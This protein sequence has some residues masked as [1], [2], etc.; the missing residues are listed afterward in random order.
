MTKIC[1]R[2]GASKPLAE[3]HAAPACRDGHR[4]ECRACTNEKQ[5]IRM[6]RPEAKARVK[7][8][9]SRPEIRAR[10]NAARNS[11][12]G[13]ESYWRRARISPSFSLSFALHRALKRRP[14]K[15]PITHA[16]LMAMFASQDGCC[17]ITGIKMVWQRGSLQPN[18]MTLDRIDSRSDYSS[19]NI[20]LICH[21]V[22]M[23]RGQMHDDEMLAM[24]RAVVAQSG[25]KSTE[26]TWQNFHHF[27]ENAL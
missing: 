17:A 2:C 7:E 26:P 1:K 4:G 25:A 14:S 3:F 19:G 12:K 24:A 16:E 11:P 27:T 22:N 6:A 18:S 20:R 9:H 13:K 15:N 23:F 8:Y 10:Q 5:C 21:A